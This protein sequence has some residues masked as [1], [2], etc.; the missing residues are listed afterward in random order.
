MPLESLLAGR[1]R[2]GAYL[3]FG[4]QSEIERLLGSPLP[5]FPPGETSRRGLENIW[6]S[7][8]S[9]L[10]SSFHACLVRLVDS[11][12][13][14]KRLRAGD[15]SHHSSEYEALLAE[16]LRHVLISD[17]RLGLTNL[18]W[19]AHSLQ[20]AEVMEDYFRESGA[21][22]SRKYQIHPLLSGLYR[23]LEKSVLQGFKKAEERR[24]EFRRG[25]RRNRSLVDT[26]TNDQF[27]LT[28][29]D[30]RGFDPRRALLPENRRFRIGAD[31]C[32]EMEKILQD[33]IEKAITGEDDYV[34]GLLGP[35]SGAVMPAECL[36]QGRLD[37]FIYQRPV[38]EGLLR[39]VEGVV[40]PVTRNRILKGE[41]ERLG[42]WGILFDA[43]LDL[44]DALL[45]SQVVCALRRNLVFSAKGFDDRETR[46]KFTEGSLYRFSR[47]G[48]IM[49]NV[50]KVTVLFAD[51]RD[52]LKTS[53]KAI[54]ESDLT[55]QLY[56]IFDPAA[57]VMSTFGGSIDKY[58]GDGFMATFGVNRREGGGNM[59][60]LRAAVAMQHMLTKLRRQEKT[61][62][63]MG[64]SLHTG[65][66]SVARFLLDAS[67]E[68]TTPIGRQVNIAGRLSSPKGLIVNRPA[69]GTGEPVPEKDAAAGDLPSPSE[70]VLLDAEG[71]M[72]NDG[73]VVSG[74]FLEELK[75]TPGLDSFHH[76]GGR[77]YILRDAETSL[78]MRFDYVGEAG[79]K[80][81][82]GSISIFSL[83]A[84][85]RKESGK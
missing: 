38:V 1:L 42:G 49:N 66:V 6:V 45:R 41:K 18:F 77:G 19:V 83:A 33:R 39:D 72:R 31:A 4:G 58:L 9:E 50:R 10:R 62:F 29:T 56:R 60:A 55:S 21:N 20:V 76:E 79:F 5:V 67:R 71:I 48:E 78:T 51:L 61:D 82:A 12:R 64:I 75:D 28:E 37:R 23:R 57:M 80:G 73:I 35:V 7:V 47:H 74:A 63:R 68:E 27:S 70:R 11:V 52:F 22:L 15:T 59:A 16:T 8:H 65:R 43:Y 53:E 84:E 34:M 2:G 40:N 30:L 69:V 3:L 46:D 36:R 85:V 13:G 81:F 26:V 14:A 24:L 54:S 17:R 44:G 25:A 32:E